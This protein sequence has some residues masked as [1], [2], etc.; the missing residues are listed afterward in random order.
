M[1]IISY[2]GYKTIKEAVESIDGKNCK[3]FEIEEYSSELD[4]VL[5][6]SYLVNGISKNKDGSIA[7]K[8]QQRDILPGLTEPD[9]LQSVQLLPGVLSPNETSSGLHI[10]G[11]TP[12]QTW[13]YLMD[14]NL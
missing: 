11:G 4:E 1:L 13:F 14:K 5:I 3:T 6:N 8:P 7:I 10:R 12:D 9:I 2:G